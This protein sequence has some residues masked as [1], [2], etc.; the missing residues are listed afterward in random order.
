MEIED[1]DSTLNSPILRGDTTFLFA[2]LE[3]RLPTSPSSE[4]ERVAQTSLSPNLIPQRGQQIERIKT[5]SFLM[6]VYFDDEEFRCQPASAA[7]SRKDVSQGSAIADVAC[8]RNVLLI[9]PQQTTVPGISPQVC[10]EMFISSSVGLKDNLHL[11]LGK[12]V[13]EPR[14][15]QRR[16]LKPGHPFFLKLFCRNMSI[17]EIALSYLRVIIL[18]SRCVF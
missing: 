17:F 11:P 15:F 9:R 1:S 8:H 3:D 4:K 13:S 12:P 16:R 10:S 5:T 18:S 7:C 14:G 6:R 2:S